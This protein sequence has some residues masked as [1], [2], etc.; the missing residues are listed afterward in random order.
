M[1]GGE[2]RGGQASALMS[3][4]KKER[5]LGGYS[6]RII[7][8]LDETMQSQLGLVVNVH[9]LRLHGA[10]VKQTWGV[11]RTHHGQSSETH[12]HVQA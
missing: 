6:I 5:E 11:E 4:G 9:L 12:S 1:L 2:G 10:W 7:P 8:H 3:R